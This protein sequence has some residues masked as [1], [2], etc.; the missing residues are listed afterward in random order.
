MAW[1][2]NV[3]TNAPTTPRIVV[4]MNPDGLLCPGERSRAIM[5]ATKPIKMIQMMLIGSAPL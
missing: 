4:R 1:P 3:A 2:I 5:P